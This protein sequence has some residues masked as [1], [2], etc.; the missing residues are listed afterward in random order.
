VTAR[1]LG[2]LAATA[3]AVAALA[4]AP[5]RAQSPR[6]LALD[7][8]VDL[9]DEIVVGHVVGSE[10][11]WQGKL[12]V[13]VTAVD[14]EE[15]LKGAPGGRVEVTQLGGT[16]VHPTLGVP[17]TMTASSFAPLGTGEHVLLFVDRHRSG[18]RQLVGGPQG[19]LTLRDATAATAPPAVAVGPKALAVTRDHGA[20]ALAPTPMTLDAIRRRIQ[21][22]LGRTTP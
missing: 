16:A 6:P 9:A 4:G 2:R 18:I 21:E 22:R 12:I 1:R 5:A 20:A 8:M 10:A 7:E 13:T 11:H 15:S 14:V 19:K 3:L 17:I